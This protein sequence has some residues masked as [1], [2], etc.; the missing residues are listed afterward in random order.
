MVAEDVTGLSW[1]VF[2]TTVMFNLQIHF[3]LHVTFDKSTLTRI[4]VI[5]DI[6]SCERYMRER[7]V[8]DTLWLGE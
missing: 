7:P 8:A 1:W 5:C 2:Q 6:A 3:V 4:S